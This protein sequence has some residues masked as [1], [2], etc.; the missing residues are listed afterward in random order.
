MTDYQ[1]GC[2]EVFPVRLYHR[3]VVK[4]YPLACLGYVEGCG[5]RL[6]VRFYHECCCER[7]T[8]GL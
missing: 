5:D 1:L 8:V 4:D 7:R 3:Y 2:M 6:P